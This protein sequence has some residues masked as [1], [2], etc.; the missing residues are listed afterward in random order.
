MWT[1]NRSRLHILSTLSTESTTPRRQVC[2]FKVCTQTLHK[3]G[4][5]DSGVEHIGVRTRKRAGTLEGE[6][7]YGEGTFHKVWAFLVDD[8]NDSKED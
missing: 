8:G 1:R 4:D 2:L 6:V 7:A 3:L 5:N